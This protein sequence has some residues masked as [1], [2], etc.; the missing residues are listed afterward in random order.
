MTK[1]TPQEMVNALSQLFLLC[2]DLETD[3]DVNAA[4]REFG[5]D[6]DKLGAR[7]DKATEQKLAEVRSALA[8]KEKGTK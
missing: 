4:L 5:Y 7:F 1:R 3:E 2:H 6:P 8:D